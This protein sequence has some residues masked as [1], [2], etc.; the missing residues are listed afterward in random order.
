MGYVLLDIGDKFECGMTVPVTI[1][2]HPM[3]AL[4]VFP[5]RLLFLTVSCVNLSY[6]SVGGVLSKLLFFSSVIARGCVKS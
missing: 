2:T 3:E 6:P 1:S 5:V 4:F